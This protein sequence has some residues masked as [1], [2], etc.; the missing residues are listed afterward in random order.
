MDWT[1]T[2]SA[3]P[4][5]NAESRSDLCRQ[6]G[7]LT[8]LS[9]VCDLAGRIS[10]FRMQA[11]SG[12]TLAKCRLRQGRLAEAA[13]T[14]KRSFELIEAKNL[15][16]EW[17]AEPLNAFAE[18]NLLEAQRLSGS[19]AIKPSGSPPG[20]LEG[21]GLLARRPDMAGRDAASS[22]DAGVAVERHPIRGG[23]VAKEPRHRGARWH[24]GR[25][26]AHTARDGTVVG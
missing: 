22:W 12:G 24:A 16:G 21:S 2:R 1:I 25:T 11:G 26:S 20:V 18:L 4:T 3:D 14:L 8:H 17:L 23:L 6:P 15:R 7:P 5:S 13:A 19:A 10:A 9:A